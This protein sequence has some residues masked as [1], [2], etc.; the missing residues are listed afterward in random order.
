MRGF[1]WGRK[2]CNYKKQKQNPTTLNSNSAFTDWLIQNYF[3]EVKSGTEVSLRRAL[4]EELLCLLS[5]STQTVTC[6]VSSPRSPVC[7]LYSLG[8]ASVTVLVNLL[9]QTSLYIP[10]MHVL[11]KIQAHLGECPTMQKI[12]YVIWVAILLHIEIQYMK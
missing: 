4:R 12:L 11:W 8:S 2:S 6:V 5:L 10:L 1:V 7:H 3:S 9:Q